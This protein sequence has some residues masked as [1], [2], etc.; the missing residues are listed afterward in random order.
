[1]NF[2]KADYVRDEFLEI[3]FK[4]TNQIEEIKSIINSADQVIK[5][6]VIEKLI[7]SNE[8]KYIEQYLLKNIQNIQDSEEMGKTAEVLV[9]LQNLIG[10][11][12]YVD[13]VKR[14]V[15]NEI[16]LKRAACI[17]ALKSHHAIPHLI[18]LLEISYIKNILVRRFNPF[19]S[20][21]ISA[22]TNIGLEFEE[23]LESVSQELHK[24][25]KDKSF[26]NP[27]VK[28]LFQN[29]EQHEIRHLSCASVPFGSDRFA[30][31]QYHSDRVLCY[32][33]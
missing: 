13:W 15:E 25:I 20:Q 19:S 28:Y 2:K 14:H 9:T 22:L 24:F 11:N 7:D 5:W 12:L 16:D 1:M 6:S 26:L 3:F 4:E 18:E 33:A 23:N 21:I 10:L 29:I 17:G 32:S 8:E 27:N 31:L 30:C